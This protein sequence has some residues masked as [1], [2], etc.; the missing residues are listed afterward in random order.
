MVDFI[1]SLRAGMSAGEI[2]KK[3]KQEIEAVF[4]ELNRQLTDGF[5]KQVRIDIKTSSDVKTIH[6]I[7]NG[8]FAGRSEI[9]ASNPQDPDAKQVALAR[10]RI[11]AG[12]YPCNIIMRDKEIACEDRQALEATLQVMLASPDVGE[13]IVR[14]INLNPALA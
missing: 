5:G 2:A 6:D 4:A 12:G 11:S 13:K 9:V 7:F 14:L 10:I 1:T 8:Q 3:N